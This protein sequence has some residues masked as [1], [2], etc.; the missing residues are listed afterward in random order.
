MTE[1]DDLTA[2]TIPYADLRHYTASL[3][4]AAGAPEAD[5]ELMGECLAGNDLHGSSG[6]GTACAADPNTGG[7]QG[8]VNR[9]LPGP[10]Q[11]VNPAP[12]VQMV[13]HSGTTAVFD[14]DGGMGHIACKKAVDWAIGAAKEH[15]T[16]CVTTRNHFHFGGESPLLR[17]STRAISAG[18]GTLI[19]VA[20]SA[21]GTWTRYA[22]QENC[23]AIAVSSHRYSDS[24]PMISP[25]KSIHSVNQTSPISIGVPAGEEADLV[26]D[27]GASFGLS[28]DLFESIPSLQA[29]FFKNLAVGTADQT[30]APT[31]L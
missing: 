4:A 7:W 15:G 14:G 20:G 30:H 17:S 23:L 18:S 12:N 26:L 21:A 25:D 22:L 3:F 13:E 5:A 29:A 31:I 11:S 10:D 27:M 19:Y 2:L 28:L 1:K 16:A 8:Y 9:M 6:H 24:D